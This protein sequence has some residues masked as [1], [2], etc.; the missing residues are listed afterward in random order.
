M[1]P[2]SSGYQCTAPRA[3]RNSSIDIGFLCLLITLKTSGLYK[4]LHPR[5]IVRG[6]SR[7]DR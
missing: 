5:I 4:P 2:T 6:I 1:Y 3:F 7:K